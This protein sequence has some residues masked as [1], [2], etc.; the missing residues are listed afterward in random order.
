MN[1]FALVREEDD[2]VRRVPL[3]QRVQREIVALFEEQVLQLNVAD[4]EIIDFDPAY[5]L[6]DGELFRV[7]DFGVPEV[8]AS[9]IQRP[10]ECTELEA[11]EESFAQVRGLFFGSLEDEGWVGLQ[12]FDA[13]R[14]LSRSGFTIL[15]SGNTYRRLDE[16][17]LTLDSHVAAVLQG[18]GA[19]FQ[20]YHQARR[21]LDLADSY[22][23]ATEDQVQEFLNLECLHVDD[24][25]KFLAL[26]DSWVRKK[27]ALILGR[28]TLGQRPPAEI[29][30]LAARFGLQIQLHG[31]G[32]GA[33]LKLPEMKRDMKRVLRFLDED[34]FESV[35]TET[36]FVTN[37]KRQA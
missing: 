35:I 4:S 25:A 7:S 5:K 27:I 3:A 33:S 32:P 23:E 31:N 17:G 14:M 30:D 11:G 1:L 12:V 19:Y 18:G 29:V 36:N 34:Y 16:P 6:D 28:G 13:R 26:A 10:L 24:E 15:F 20:S 21:I 8:I 9:A 2:P 22:E 37:S